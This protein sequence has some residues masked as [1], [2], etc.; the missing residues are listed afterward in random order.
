MHLEEQVGRELSK[1]IGNV[2]DRQG[3]A[4][5]VVGYAE[6]SLQSCDSS[7]SQ[8]GTVLQRMIDHSGKR[9]LDVMKLTRKDRK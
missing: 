7:I 8:V 5:L 3:D 4:V 9:K 1:N 2:G 6:V